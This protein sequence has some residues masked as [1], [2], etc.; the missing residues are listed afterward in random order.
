MLPNSNIVDTADMI[1]FA[2]LSILLLGNIYRMY[3]FIVGSVHSYPIPLTSYFTEFIKTVPAHFFAQIRFLKCKKENIDWIMHIITVYGYAT[4][5]VLVV[6]FLRWFQTNTMYPIY[7]P[8]RLAGYIGSALLLI[9]ILYGIYGRIMKNSAR[10]RFS[11]ST[12]WFFLTM[13]FLTVITGLATNIFKYLSMPLETYIT[14]TIHLGFAAP[15]LILE[16]P[17]AKWSHLAYRPFAI[18]FARLKE[19]KEVGEYA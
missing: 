18:Y 13:L 15:L 4:I 11:H 2:V 9:G 1:V 5:F 16:V 17:F 3:K 7:H 12:D 6:I 10:R 8:I 14:Y 19:I